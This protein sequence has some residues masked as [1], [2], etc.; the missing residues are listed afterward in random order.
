MS[1]AE[2]AS[3]YYYRL[4]AMTPGELGYRISERLTERRAGSFGD[5]S[6]AAVIPRQG[7]DDVD[8]SRVFLRLKAGTPP[9]HGH[10]LVT[11]L[12]QGR[13]VVLGETWDASDPHWQLD[14]RSGVEWPSGPARSI[15]YRGGD[16]SDPK[17]TWEINRLAFLLALAADPAEPGDVALIDRL[18]ADWLASVPAG[19]GVAWSSSIEVALRSVALTTLYR[20]IPELSA[21]TRAACERSLAQ[22]ARWLEMFPSKYSSANNHR[23]AELMGL[24]VLATHWHGLD[25]SVTASVPELEAECLQV[26]SSL[27]ADDGI[28]LEE[29]PTYSGFAIELAALAYLGHDW[30][31]ASV[32]SALGAVLRTACATL[33]QFTT[34]SGRLIS[35]GDNDEA[36]VLTVLSPEHDYP[37]ALSRLL[38][39]EPAT[40]RQGLITFADGGHSVIRGEDAGGTVW[41]FDHAP[42]GFGALAAHGHADALSVTLHTG[43]HDWIVD[44]GTYCYHA[45]RYWR[46]WFRSSAAHNGPTFGGLNS[47]T[48]TGSFNWHPRLRAQ[49]RLLISESDGEH[50]E[51]R[52]EHDGYQRSKVGPVVRRTLSRTGPG[53]YEILDECPAAPLAL[54][55]RFIL[56]PRCRIEP[57]G[58]DSWTVTRPDTRVALHLTVTGA[59]TVEAIAAEDEQLW[60]SP[61]FGTRVP[62]PG[63]L[64]RGRAGGPQSLGISITVENPAILDAS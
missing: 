53:R 52:A 19:Q 45:E 35:Y 36:R 51:V 57:K 34:P 44:P 50:L 61:T 11:Q 17:W 49:T 4:R 23:L 40:R 14:P 2:R 43:G 9:E 47:S 30:S 64:L 10:E 12:R 7:P 22:H 13:V 25:D 62:A 33:M 39:L 63:L 24:L 18:L 59:E 28:G 21:P 48:P 55:T 31:D 27:F 20:L 5:E 46:D 1:V 37:A 8:I 26:A 54:Q 29:S 41:T 6:V 38:G 15:S 60:F 42:L 32:R 16:T 56:H 58:P 3:W